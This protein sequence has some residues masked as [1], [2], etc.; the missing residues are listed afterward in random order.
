M[1][2]RGTS[3]LA[4]KRALE[5]FGLNALGV[6]TAYASLLG[7]GAPCI[8]QLKNSRGTPNHFVVLCEASEDRVKIMDPALGRIEWISK[9]SFI[10]RWSGVAL[11]ISK[12]ASPLRQIKVGRPAESILSLIA[13]VKTPVT[14]LIICSILAALL[15]VALSWQVRLVM[16]YAVQDRN[17]E[18]LRLISL[19]GTIFVLWRFAFSFLGV[20]LA[21]SIGSFFEGRALEMMFS[22]IE[23]AP[24]GHF[25]ETDQI[26]H[27]RKL[28]E[29]VNTRKLVAAGISGLFASVFLFSLCLV[30]ILS[31]DIQ[32]FITLIV[33]SIILTVIDFT[34]QASVERACFR[35]A[36]A[37]DE[38]HD[39]AKTYFSSV[40]ALKSSGISRLYGHSVYH[41]YMRLTFTNHWQ[42]PDS[43]SISSM[44]SL[45][46]GM[47]NV[48]FIY[49][50][51]SQMMGAEIS[52]SVFFTLYLVSGLAVGARGSIVSSWQSLRAVHSL[53]RSIMDIPEDPTERRTAKLDS[54]LPVAIEK[55]SY[56]PKG[57]VKVVEELSF[58][59]SA[60]QCVWARGSDRTSRSA[61]AKLLR[62][63]H[64]PDEGNITFG[65]INIAGVEYNSICE[66]SSYLMNP[67]IIF[68]GTLLQNLT[69]FDI[70]ID[71][72]RLEYLCKSTGLT[73]MLASSNLNYDAH[74]QLVCHAG[75]AE[76]IKLICITRSL[77]SNPAFIIL[78]EPYSSLSDS[79]RFK[80]DALLSTEMQQGKSIFIAS[81][82]TP[83]L[84]HTSI[85]ISRSRPTH[86]QK[87]LI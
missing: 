87:P 22:K 76:L 38:F 49:L 58:T 86:A 7:L 69:G 84:P 33:Y 50:G 62:G 45:L 13:N 74:T 57:K 61:L 5:R 43:A 71:S 42:A 16:D 41:S 36:G 27:I 77:Y 3:L 59:I 53:F 70:S 48:V 34:R 12:A 54:A 79:S 63:I 56:A 72:E 25:S 40:D 11:L 10:S 46:T 65:G 75:T 81:E 35:A 24:I 64:Q 20:R 37:Y 21:N 32:L 8:I 78:D 83:S 28:K 73:A 1:T 6:K 67:P 29:I 44:S 82:Q 52:T 55:V 47:Y 60:G 23:A 17:K 15:G 51:T 18:V 4:I 85:D 19:L 68:D 14:S 9:D 80:L 26:A 30:F 66:N 31:S 39:S 2:D